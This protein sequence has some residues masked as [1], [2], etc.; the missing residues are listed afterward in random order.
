VIFDYKGESCIRLTDLY[1]SIQEP[2]LMAPF[3]GVPVPV[4]VRRLRFSQIRSCGN[5][6]LIETMRD[7]AISKHNKITTK[8]MV[9]YSELQFKIIKKS[10]LNPTYEEIMS[11]SEYDLLRVNAE[12]EL[13]ELE[14]IIN[15][16]PEGIE[17]KELLEKYYTTEMNSRYLLPADFVSFIMRFALQQDNSDILEV[18][19]DMLFESAILA[20]NGSDNPSDHLTGNFTEFNKYDI[21]NRA[22]II[23]HQRMAKNGSSN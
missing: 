20:K 16:L 18:T 4:I 10:L 5:F 14:E 9:E 11:L 15:D 6:S 12:K 23:Y 3:F 7:R 13:I 8:Q 19:E 21:D 17:K 1:K 22:W 2:A